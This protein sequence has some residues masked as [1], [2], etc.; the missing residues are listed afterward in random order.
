VG[1]IGD[2][3]CTVGGIGDVACTVGFETISICGG[4]DAPLDDATLITV[5]CDFFASS[6]TPILLPF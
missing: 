2:V 1:G 4:I 5:Y 6:F 3:A